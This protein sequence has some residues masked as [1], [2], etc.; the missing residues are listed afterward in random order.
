V[1]RLFVSVVVNLLLLGALGF[2][3][4]PQVV[5]KNT[6][7][8]AAIKAEAE[9]SSRAFTNGDMGKVLDLT[10][11]KL[12][13]IGGGREKVLAALEGQ[14]KE[15]RELGMKIIAHTVGEP[16]PSVR[17]GAKLVAIVPTVLKM[18]SRES[19]FEQK[20]FWLAVSTDEGKNWR[21]LDGSSLDANA[22]KL[23]LPEAVDKIKLP[24]VG[25]PLMERKP[26]N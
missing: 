26:A 20:S 14:L 3:Q 12:I 15:L 6:P 17:A 19:I 25:Q 11:P 10:Y 18:E 1:K 24:K 2:A 8:A 23:L 21:F 13:E 7:E 16:E 22:L 9:N 4:Q 5:S